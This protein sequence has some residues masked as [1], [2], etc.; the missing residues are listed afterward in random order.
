MCI[1]SKYI[2]KILYTFF[3]FNNKADLRWMPP[4]AV[5]TWPCSRCAGNRAPYAGH[6]GPS[7]LAPRRN[8][9]IGQCHDSTRWPS[10]PEILQLLKGPYRVYLGPHRIKK[11]KKLEI[12]E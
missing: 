5:A 4:L 11:K 1:T 12:L 9:R 8:P 2:S 10:A 3:L 7:T 6:P